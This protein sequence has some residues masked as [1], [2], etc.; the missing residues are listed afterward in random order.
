[1][2]GRMIRSAIQ[3]GVVY[4][5][6]GGDS[7]VRPA[8]AVNPTVTYERVHRFEGPPRFTP[9]Y[10]RPHRSLG[11]RFDAGLLTVT[12]ADPV[13]LAQVAAEITQALLDQLQAGPLRVGSG[14]V[15]VQLVLPQQYRNT[16]GDHLAALDRDNRPPT[17]PETGAGGDQ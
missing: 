14:A 11:G 9:T 7:T 4:A 17:D 10:R 16:W 8:V 2:V 3:P 5:V 1:M 15:S 12:G 6:A 13:L